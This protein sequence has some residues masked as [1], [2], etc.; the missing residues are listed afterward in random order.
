MGKLRKGFLY[1]DQY[2]HIKGWF[3]QKDKL[4]YVTEFLVYPKYRNK[5]H[6]RQLAK[7]LPMPCKL[8]AFPLLTHRG[9]HISE[10]KL[11]AF[12]ESL[13]FVLQ[14]KAHEHEN[15]LMICHEQK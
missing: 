9:P 2:G 6:A 14:S 15:N 13:G 11:V 4:W 8:Y 12:Y 5:G 3:D 7:H 10:E 1:K